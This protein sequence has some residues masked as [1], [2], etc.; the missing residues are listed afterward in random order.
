MALLFCSFESY[1]QVELDKSRSDTL[2]RSI[3]LQGTPRDTMST[4]I[5]NYGFIGAQDSCSITKKQGGGKVLIKIYQK[6]NQ[7]LKAQLIIKLNYSIRWDKKVRKKIWDKNGKV[8]QKSIIRKKNIY[9]DSKDIIPGRGS[10]VI[11]IKSVTWYFKKNG[12]FCLKRKKT[13]K[14]IKYPS[15]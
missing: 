3:V 2:E 4:L 10:N 9:P 6:E 5:E 12:Q 14:S 1:G 13:T 7:V 8:V 15:N 11:G